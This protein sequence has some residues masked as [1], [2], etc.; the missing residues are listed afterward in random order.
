MFHLGAGV[1][2]LAESIFAYLLT[3]A[4]HSSDSYEFYVLLI[5]FVQRN[6][7]ISK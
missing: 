5:T 3:V 1:R 2:I 4:N 6:Q 7:A